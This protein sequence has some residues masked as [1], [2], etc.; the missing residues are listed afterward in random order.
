MT[1]KY[2]CFRYLTANIDKYVYHSHSTSYYQKEM[3]RDARK[4]LSDSYFF[5][6]FC[7]LIL[8]LRNPIA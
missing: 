1:L 7:D 4:T 8:I 3:K 6:F 5:F 2:F